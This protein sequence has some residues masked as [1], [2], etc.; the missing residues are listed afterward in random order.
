MKIGYNSMQ[1]CP[2]PKAT[3]FQRDLLPEEIVGLE[4]NNAGVYNDVQ[5]LIREGE[6]RKDDLSKNSLK[7][8]YDEFAKPM[9]KRLGHFLDEE[10]LKLIKK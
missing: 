4:N 1:N 7:L 9:L 10:A 2:R 3:S 5:F 8:F 6:I